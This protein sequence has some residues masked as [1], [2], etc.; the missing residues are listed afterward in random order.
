MTTMSKKLL[1]IVLSSALFLQGCVTRSDGPKLSDAPKPPASSELATVYIYYLGGPETEISFYVNE[2]TLFRANPVSFTWVQLQP[3]KHTFSAQVGF[4]GYNL[5]ASSESTE[6]KPTQ[7]SF[8]L[9]PGEKY[10]LEFSTSGEM[11]RTQEHFIYGVGIVGPEY[12]E[13]GKQIMEVEE[14][15]ALWNMKAMDYIEPNF[16][17]PRQ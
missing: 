11:T 4:W 12:T 1:F 7:K 14:D 2:K 16:K 9:K 13:Y 8:T 10:Y 17:G 5:A 15:V 6:N 3:G